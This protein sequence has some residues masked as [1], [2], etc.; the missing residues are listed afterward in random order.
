MHKNARVCICIGLMSI[1]NLSTKECE[2]LYEDDHHTY[3]LCVKHC[4]HQYR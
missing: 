4:F 1:I 3:K 2:I